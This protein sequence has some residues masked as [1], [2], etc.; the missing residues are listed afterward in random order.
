MAAAAEQACG[1]KDLDA[2]GRAAELCLEAGTR[3]PLC[4]DR[5]A[6][7]LAATA[8][9]AEGGDPE[10]WA[11]LHSRVRELRARLSPADPILADRVVQRVW[12]EALL[13][14]YG[15]ARLPNGAPLSL[16]PPE[17][18]P[19]ARA[20]VAWR[21]STRTEQESLAERAD[22][23][24]ELLSK[25]ERRRGGAPMSAARVEVPSLWPT[26]LPG[27]EGLGFLPYL[28][29]ARRTFASEPRTD[30]RICVLE[31]AARLR[32]PDARL[33]EEGLRD[34]DR[35]VRWTAARLLAEVLPDGPALA[36]ARQDADPLVRQRAAS[37]SR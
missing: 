9:A 20:A 8:P 36:R 2:C 26:D 3:R 28:Q 7:A 37:V 13:V 11:T 16:L 25:R 4:L 24:L 29:G 27:E 18:E 5:I 14:A 1:G 33:L 19:H 34:E 35:R 23:V 6:R 30:A 21:L 10:A 17:V 12:A 22:L 31:A 15:L 32:P